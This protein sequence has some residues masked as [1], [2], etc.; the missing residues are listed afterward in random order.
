ML[1]IE[2]A[3]HRSGCPRSPLLGPG[4]GDLP[5]LARYSGPKKQGLAP[6]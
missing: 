3:Q 6:L 5:V 4:S 1:D 2:R